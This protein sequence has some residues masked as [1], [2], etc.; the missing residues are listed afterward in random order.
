VPG[1]S[2]TNGPDSTTMGCGVGVADVLTG[3]PRRI[4]STGRDCAMG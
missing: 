4:G 2:L 3:L 1:T